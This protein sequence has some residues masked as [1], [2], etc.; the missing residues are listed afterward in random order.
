MK[1]FNSKKNKPL[2]RNLR[3][4]ATPHE[5]KLWTYLRRDQL[6]YRFRRQYGIG[7]YIVD[8]YC[9]DKKLVVELDGSHHFEEDAIN[10]DEKRTEFLESLDYTVLRFTDSDINVNIEGVLLKISEVLRAIS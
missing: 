10:Y 2:R 4:A 9:P 8:F 7:K 6:G 1:I 3:N 5:I